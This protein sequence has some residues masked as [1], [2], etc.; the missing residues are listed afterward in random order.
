MSPLLSHPPWLLGWGRG[1]VGWGRRL[2]RALQEGKW[3]Y[4]GKGSLGSVVD[5]ETSGYFRGGIWRQWGMVAP[6]LRS[7][8]R[9]TIGSRAGLFFLW[10]QLKVNCYHWSRELERRGVALLRSPHGYTWAHTPRYLCWW[11][12][13]TVHSCIHTHGHTH[14][15]ACVQTST[16]TAVQTQQYAHVRIRLGPCVIGRG[17]AGVWCGRRNGFL[18]E[19]RSSPALEGGHGMGQVSVTSP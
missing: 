14:L 8:W 6:K 17:L 19:W 7:R 11:T 10:A 16:C 12:H 15:S 18:P 3:L 5:S 9:R 4:Y 1:T 13:V 2:G